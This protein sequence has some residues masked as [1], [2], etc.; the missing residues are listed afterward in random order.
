MECKLPV[1]QVHWCHSM[2]DAVSFSQLF[3]GAYNCSYH[4]TYVMIFTCRYNNTFLNF[5]LQG[6]MF[7]IKY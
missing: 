6:D 5:F 2:S 3:G 1:A 4:G 7:D